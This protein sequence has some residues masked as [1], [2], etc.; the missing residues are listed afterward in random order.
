[1]NLYLE[2]GYLNIKAIL[3]LHLPFNFIV[4]GRGTGKTFGA[5][6]HVIDNNIKFMFMRRTQSQL[7]LINKPE[8]SP[9]KPL[10]TEYGWDIT[11]ESLSKYNAGFYHSTTVEDGKIQA[12]GAPLGYSCALSTISNLRGF[13]ASDVELL[14]YDEF[15]PE[16]HER[17]IKD[18]GAALLN[19]Y[20]TMN[21]NR[22]LNGSNPLTL[23]CLANANDLG[24]PIFMELGLISKAESMRRK[25]QEYSIDTKRGIGLFI[26]NESPIS[27]AKKNTALYRASSGSDYSDMALENNFIELRSESIKSMPIKEFKPICTIGEITIYKHKSKRS[28]YISQHSTGSPESFGVSDIERSRWQ[29]KYYWIWVEYMN[30]NIV[31]ENS[32]CEV[33]LTK[34]SK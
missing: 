15:I 29:K 14:I 30:N 1:M 4:G 16:R 28:Y 2:S 13:D 27:D 33:L 3:N 26:L 19:A 20:E 9:F 22:E 24:N 11:S 10:N 6:K 17:P 7:D 12:I 23:L 32:T 31:F 5:L 34:Y 25:G 21:R 18:E 8:F